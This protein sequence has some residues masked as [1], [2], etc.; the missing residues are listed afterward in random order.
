MPNG[1]LVSPSGR[2]IAYADGTSL[3]LVNSDSAAVVLSDTI[4]PGSQLHW[5]KGTDN[6]WVI[7]DGKADLVSRAGATWTRT[8]MATE[9]LPAEVSALL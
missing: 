4:P 8:A 7:H 5:Q 1:G 6:L 9:D 3:T 2:Y